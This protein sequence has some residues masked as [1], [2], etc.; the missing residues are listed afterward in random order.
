MSTRAEYWTMSPSEWTAAEIRD[1]Y[2]TTRVTLLTLAGMLG[3]TGGELQTILNGGD[4]DAGG[5]H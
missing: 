1:Y 2:A 5:G 3:L 4:A